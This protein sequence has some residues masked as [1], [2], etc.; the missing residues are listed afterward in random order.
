[1]HRVLWRGYLDAHACKGDAS[2][3]EVACGDVQHVITWEVVQRFH[4]DE[5]VAMQSSFFF[6]NFV[7]AY[8]L[9]SALRANVLHELLYRCLIVGLVGLTCQDELV[10]DRVLESMIGH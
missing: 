8:V 10:Q 7:S 6:A 9:H 3:D 1:M 5:Y 2:S 4:D